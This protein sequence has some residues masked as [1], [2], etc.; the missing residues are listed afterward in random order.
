MIEQFYLPDPRRPCT[1][2]GQTRGVSMVQL[3]V[4]SSVSRIVDS[5]LWK[6]LH[7][8]ARAGGGGVGPPFLAGYSI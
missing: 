1:R 5:V 8:H 4:H 7:V 6:V 2:P 3:I